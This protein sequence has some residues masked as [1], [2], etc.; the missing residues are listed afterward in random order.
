MALRKV[1]W[2]RILSDLPFDLEYENLY[3]KIEQGVLESPDDHI[4]V[5][6]DSSEKELVLSLKNRVMSV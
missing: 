2:I 6:L 4:L 5:E 1:Q 3:N